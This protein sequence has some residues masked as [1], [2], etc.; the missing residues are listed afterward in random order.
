MCADSKVCLMVSQRSWTHFFCI[1]VLVL[2]PVLNVSGF[3]SQMRQICPP[4]ANRIILS[5]I[6]IHNQICVL[7]IYS[8]RLINEIIL[9]LKQ[10]LTKTCVSS[11]WL[12][13]SQCWNWA[14]LTWASMSLRSASL[15]RGR[16]LCRIRRVCC[17]KMAVMYT[18][19]STAETGLLKTP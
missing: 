14:P 8:M 16:Y 17:L 12:S 10:A 19:L 18:V 7:Y 13:Q 3:W 9:D 6:L 1:L 15:Y 4:P 11:L 5:F 2:S